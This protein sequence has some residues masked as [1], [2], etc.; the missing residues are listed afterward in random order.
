MIGA[1]ET[2]KKARKERKCMQNQKKR[3]EQKA[4]DGDRSVLSSGQKV[5]VKKQK[6][7]EVQSSWSD[8][9]LVGQAIGPK[10]VNIKKSSS[11]VS[12]RKRPSTTASKHRP[13]SMELSSQSQSSLSMTSSTQRIKK[14]LSKITTADV[15]ARVNGTRSMLDAWRMLALLG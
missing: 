1:V 2:L 12:A 7:V 6:K 9:E 11:D 13:S 3:E 15:P 8:L 14:P 4:K 10:G 5:V